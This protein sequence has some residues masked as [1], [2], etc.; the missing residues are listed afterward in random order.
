MERL[1]LLW[2]VGIFVC[3]FCLGGLSIRDRLYELAIIDTGSFIRTLGV[4]GVVDWLVLYRSVDGSYW[5]CRLF[6]GSYRLLVRVDW[7]MVD[8]NISIFWFELWYNRWLLAIGE[9]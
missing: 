8:L 5:D 7:G 4:L 3:T 1:N 6:G 2:T 9:C